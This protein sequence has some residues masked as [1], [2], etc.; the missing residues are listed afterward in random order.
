MTYNIEFVDIVE[1][2]SAASAII[3]GI[4]AIVTF[5]I[6]PICKHVTNIRKMVVNIDKIAADLKPNG[7]SSLKDQINRIEHKIIRGEMR[8][9]ALIRDYDCGIFECDIEGNNI[10]VN[11]TYCK[12]IGVPATKLLGKEWNN[13]I[14]PDYRN[15]YDLHWSDKFSQCEEV[16]TVV[17][18][19]N[20][21]GELL[22]V[23]I[24]AY[25]LKDDTQSNC[26]GY[27]GM[28]FLEHEEL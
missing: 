10:Y 13:Y 19:V 21:S 25:P 14:H 23:V 9:R 12:M 20:G 17:V 22:N 5:I 28:V 6:K 1:F 26:V 24:K 18:M 11:R 4:I 8:S 3:A 2:F 7:G 27:F 15:H 16:E